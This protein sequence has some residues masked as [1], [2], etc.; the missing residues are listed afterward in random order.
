[1]PSGRHLRPFVASTCAEMNEER[2]ESPGSAGEPVEDDVQGIE[3][4]SSETDTISEPSPAQEPLEPSELETAENPSLDPAHKNPEDVK[5]EAKAFA[6][7][8]PVD[9]FE[10]LEEDD[11]VD[12]RNDPEEESV[13][14]ESERSESMAGS[15]KAFKK[16]YQ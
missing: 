8:P 12:S 6:C 15:E 14:G 11:D 4:K 9:W 13:A 10:P 7:E 2:L 1:M 3:K 5:E 16:I